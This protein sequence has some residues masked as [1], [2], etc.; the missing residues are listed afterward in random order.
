M[1]NNKA[2]MVVSV[3]TATILKVIG[4]LVALAF[5][6]FIR[7]ILLVFFVALIFASAFGPWVDW[8]NR[9]KIPRS[10]GML[11]IYLI[12]L[13]IVSLVVFLIV[14]PIAQQTGELSKNFP[15]YMDGIAKNFSAFKGLSTQIKS[16]D[17]LSQ[18]LNK[19]SE[20]FQ[21]NAGNVFETL[22]GIFGGIVSFF[23]MLVIT[24]YM[25][26][27]ENAMSKIIMSTVRYKHQPYILGLISRMQ[28]K[29]G[30]W[31]RGQFILC[32]TVGLMIFIGLE[33]LHVKYALVLAIIA[34][35]TEFV[36]YL[37]PI[38]GAIPAVFLA[39]TVSPALGLVVAVFYYFVQLT[40]NHI[41]VPKIMQKTVGLNPVVSIAVLLIGFKLAGIPGAILSIPVATAASVVIEDMLEKNADE[42]AEERG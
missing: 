4:I 10:I 33:I 2:K 30:L 14:P 8:L 13:F 15:R 28:K 19:I 41:L 25:A 42:I 31:L 18:G 21:A 38:I 12:A 24:F 35:I 36:P 40:E 11:S 39:F 3:S 6:F 23:L 1:E 37:G 32:F 22:K 7:D 5:L 9:K 29:I 26:V 27:E 17:S 20:N 16:F 34:G